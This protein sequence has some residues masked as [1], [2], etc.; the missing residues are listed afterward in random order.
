MESCIPVYHDT[1]LYNSRAVCLLKRILK[2][3]HW[4]LLK[5]YHGTS[6]G[7]SLELTKLVSAARSASARCNIGV[8]RAW[9]CIAAPEHGGFA[10]GF[11]QKYSAQI[12]PQ[13]PLLPALSHDS[14]CENSFTLYYRV[15]YQYYNVMYN[16]LFLIKEYALEIRLGS[17]NQF[18]LTYKKR[19][20]K[21]LIELIRQNRIFHKK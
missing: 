18:K 2:C 5:V 1:G 4:P 12:W 19:A 6:A 7:G 14:L 15:V 13:M 11:E 10:W 9:V 20:L 17:P 16:A 3:V 21:Y 8:S